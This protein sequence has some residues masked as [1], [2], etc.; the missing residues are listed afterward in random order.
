MSM[1]LWAIPRIDPWFDLLKA[2]L[3][4]DRARLPGLTT[5]VDAVW[6]R[7]APWAQPSSACPPLSL[8]EGLWIAAR[9]IFRDRQTQEPTRSRELA[10]QVAKLASQL[11]LHQDG[12]KAFEWFRAVES[13]LRGESTFQ[14]E[15]WRSD[16]VGLAIQLVLAR[17]E[18][19]RFRTWFADA[20]QLPPAVAWSAAALCGLL[21]GYRGL[22]V[23]FRGPL[24]QRE[25]LAIHALS[26]CSSDASSIVWPT[27][28]S[29]DLQWRRERGEFVLSWGDRDFT[30]RPEKARGKWFS[31]SLDDAA[32]RR[33]A[34]RVARALRWNCMRREVELV[35]E[36]LTLSGSGNACVCSH[37]NL[38]LDVQG[39]LRL[40]L[41]AGAVIKESFDVERFRQCVATESGPVPDPPFPHTQMESGPTDVPGLV[42]ARDFLGEREEAELLARL[43]ACDWQTDLQRRVQHYGWRYDYKARRIDPSMKLGPLPDWAAVIASHL[44]SSG[45]LPASSRSSYCQRVH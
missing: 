19:M 6:W 37:P 31:A 1:A 36:H 10:Q 27:A 16:P 26:T 23:R 15:S 13:I 7:F 4:L 29:G 42:Y 40:Q 8:Q 2:S 38:Q 41:P 33:E 9:D 35:D 28:R 34:T 17:P 5:A 43:D 30:T 11:V 44:V 22:E 20:P 24:L 3:T 39:Q 21:H 14:F 12:D 45:L 32:T 18:P 25:L